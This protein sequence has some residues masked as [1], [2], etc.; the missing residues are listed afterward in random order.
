[1][2]WFCPYCWKEVYDDTKICPYCNSNLSEFN[3]LAYD[4]K[5]IFGLKNPIREHRDFAIYIL[6]E[7]RSA[8]ALKPL[9]ELAKNNTDTIE[10]LQ[11][12][13]ALKKI[14][15]PQSKDCLKQLSNIENELL[16]RFL[17]KLEDKDVKH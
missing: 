17:K 6:G 3:N 5:L 15:T 14:N 1:M 7:L 2:K 10:L 9:C 11:I 12:A 4:A 8:N 13:V 16:K